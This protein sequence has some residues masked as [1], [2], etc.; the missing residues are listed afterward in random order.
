M[1]CRQAWLDTVFCVIINYMSENRENKIW[2]P[3]D[4][5]VYFNFIKW[6]VI[7]ATVV[8][9]LY[10]LWFMKKTGLFLADQKEQLMWLWRVGIMVFTGFRVLS[11]FG[12]ALP[13]AIISGAFTGLAVGLVSALVRFFD[14]VM[15]WKFFNL[16]TEPIITGIIFSL[17]VAAVVFFFKQKN[18]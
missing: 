13:I 17:V 14:G 10:R 7:V 2:Q 16:V 4:F 3:V 12:D 15:I 6:T 5:N 18:K 9:A 1:N 8:E 11:K